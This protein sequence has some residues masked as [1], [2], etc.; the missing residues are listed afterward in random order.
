M[1]AYD[2]NGSKVWERE[3]DINGKVMPP[4]KDSYGRTAKETGDK[5][6]YEFERKIRNC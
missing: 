6:Y 3:L 5:N 1:E 4:R 2:E